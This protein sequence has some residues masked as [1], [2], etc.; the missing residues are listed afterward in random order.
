MSGSFKVHSVFAAVLAV[1]LL[2]FVAVTWL[3]GPSPVDGIGWAVTVMVGVVVLVPVAIVVRLR[4]NDVEVELWPV[5]RE[6]LPRPLRRVLLGLLLTAVASFALSLA[7]GD[8][9]LSGPKAHGDRYWAEY[10]RN[11]HSREVALTKAEYEVAV[12]DSQRDLLSFASC[13]ASVGAC[14]AFTARESFR[15]DRRS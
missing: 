13:V 3:P 10:G 7:H 4:L 14:V 12:E 11:H 9:D 8:P 15:V 5:F 1:A 2:L 6:E